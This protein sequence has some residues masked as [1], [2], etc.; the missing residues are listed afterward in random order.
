MLTVGIF[1]LYPAPRGE[2]RL[3]DC[4]GRLFAV[5]PFRRAVLRAMRET[6]R[7]LSIH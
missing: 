7:A 1:R 6:Y 2:W 5:L 3:V 4:G